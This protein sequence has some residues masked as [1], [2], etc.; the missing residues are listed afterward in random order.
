MN[1]VDYDTLEDLLKAQK[2][3][4]NWKTPCS[5]SQFE[6]MFS[7]YERKIKGEGYMTSEQLA[8]AKKK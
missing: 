2:K 4:M 7:A 3:A 8:A 5:H 1:N 6:A